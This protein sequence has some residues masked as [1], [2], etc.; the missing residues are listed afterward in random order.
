MEHIAIDH[1]E[2]EYWNTSDDED[3]LQGKPGNRGT[4][5]I[6]GSSPSTKLV[7]YASDEELDEA[8]EAGALVADETLAKTG[9]APKSDEATSAATP[10]ERLSEKR[11]REEDE[12]EDLG[13][14]IQH[15]RRNSTSA[16][17][18]SSS[19]SGVLRKRKGSATVRDAG[20][21]IAISLTPALSSAIKAGNGQTG[22]RQDDET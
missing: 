13:K 6:N 3:D 21:K 15:K 16:S 19:T 10:P 12:E 20:P 2:E 9:D 22:G 14:F 5:S 4:A 17:S 11:R 8:I 18:N 7:D 1:A